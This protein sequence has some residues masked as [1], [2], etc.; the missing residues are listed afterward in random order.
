M[1]RQQKCLVYAPPTHVRLIPAR[2]LTDLFMKHWLTSKW[3]FML[4]VEL[5][6]FPH[7]AIN[8]GNKIETNLPD[9]KGYRHSYT[10]NHWK[11]N[12]LRVNSLES[13]YSP[14]PSQVPSL[15]PT[16]INIKV[17]SLL[18][19]FFLIKDYNKHFSSIAPKLH[20]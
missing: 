9:E 8:T 18:F 10:D 14:I 19:I 20:S 3:I 7:I 5:I 4:A 13:I 17:S 11:Y 12:W 2:D 1:V 6:P 16:F 15:V